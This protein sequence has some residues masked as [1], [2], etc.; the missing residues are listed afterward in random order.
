MHDTFIDEMDR[1]IDDDDKEKKNDGISMFFA[2]YNESENETF[3][4]SSR[5]FA[6]HVIS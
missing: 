5:S 3:P 1:Y 4:L 2:F 6:Q